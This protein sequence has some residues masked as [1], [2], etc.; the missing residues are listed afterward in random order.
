[1]WFK[2]LCIYTLPLEWTLTA[3]SLEAEL[4]KHP[5]QP[6]SALSQQS[7][8]WI[9]PGDDARLVMDH[10]RH[11]LIALGQESKILPASVVRDE[12]AVRAELFEQQRGFKPSRKALRDMKD[13]I[14]DELL[15]RAFVKRG[16]TRAWIDGQASRIVVDATSANRA[17]TLIEQLRDALETLEAIPVQGDPSPSVTLS[18]WLAAG[19]APAP[20]VIGEECELSAP[21]E[22]KAVIRYLR[23]PLE[24]P[25]LRQHLDEGFRVTRLALIWRE[26]LS[27]VVNE[28][29]EL[30][31]LSFL[32]MAEDQEQGDD[33]QDANFALM[34]GLVSGLVDD[35]LQVMGAAPRQGG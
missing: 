19:R 20:F 12:V 29:L 8:G 30:K 28:K 1:M 2:N 11:Q 13:Q 10:E 21:D 4:A 26:Q 24:S 32:E 23:Q 9:A 3:G 22:G 17:E 16:A 35:L 15:P 6:C 27:F 33:S 14:T 31:R 5:L 7:L 25:R 18:G 34:T